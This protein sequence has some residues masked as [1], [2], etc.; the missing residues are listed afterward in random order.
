MYYIL[1]PED[2]LED[3]IYDE[4]QL[5]ESSFGTFYPGAGLS[6]LMNIVEHSPDKLTELRIIQENGTEMSVSDFLDAIKDLRIKY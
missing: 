1:L 3:C 4:N 2:K 5:G 6:G